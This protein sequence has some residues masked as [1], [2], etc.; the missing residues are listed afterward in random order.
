M[1]KTTEALN[2]LE[3]VRQ[4][5]PEK[6][7]MPWKVTVWENGKIK[8]VYHAVWI[9]MLPMKLSVIQE[10]QS[11]FI[12]DAFAYNFIHDSFTLCLGMRT[13]VETR[14][15]HKDALDNCIQTKS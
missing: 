12:R 3:I 4:D 8:T 11:Y 9:N 7:S 5:K 1:P 2:G 10:R 13:Q 15:I 6:P 14:K